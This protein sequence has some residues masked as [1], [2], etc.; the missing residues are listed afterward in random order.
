MVGG[1]TRPNIVPD[2]AYL[3]VDIRFDDAETAAQLHEAIM[4]RGG[5]GPVGG[6]SS[7][8]EV[9]EGRPAFPEGPGG[10]ELVAIF[11]AAADELGV[12][13]GI[14]STGGSSDGNFT[15][16]LGVPTL[17]GLGAIGAGYHTVDEYIEL[18]TLTGR[19]RLCAAALRRIAR[20]RDH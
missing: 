3:H 12:P 20:S 5:P 17:D 18:E 4:A 2:A 19:A 11:R 7:E 9:M 15:A 13:F 6:T 10:R 14:Q 1:G 16:A 8:V